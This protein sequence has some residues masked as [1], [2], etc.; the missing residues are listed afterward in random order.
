LPVGS[1][2]ANTTIGQVGASAG[3][4]G[5]CGTG[6]FGDQRYVVPAGGGTI[7]SFSVT[8]S[9]ASANGQREFLVLRGSGSSWK[10]IGKSGLVTLFGLGLQSVPADI[11]VQSGDILGVVIAGGPVPISPGVHSR[12]GERRRFHVGRDAG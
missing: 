10:I 6:V 12:R 3:T 9:A 2:L 4:A 8:S 7:R 11:A 1:A 5:Q